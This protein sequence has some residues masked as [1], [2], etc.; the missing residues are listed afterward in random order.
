MKDYMEPDCWNMVYSAIRLLYMVKEQTRHNNRYT[1]L[2][3]K[4]ME[5]MDKLYREGR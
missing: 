3:E 2:F 1:Q 4:H 5:E